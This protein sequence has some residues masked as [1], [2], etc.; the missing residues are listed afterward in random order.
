MYTKANRKGSNIMSKKC[1][2]CGKGSLKSASRS[3]SNKQNVHR[4]EANLH[5]V[6]AE[7]DGQVKVIKVCTSCLKKGKV[8]KAV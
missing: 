8:K 1:E 7:I 5:N 2:I 4:Q 6:R 3:F